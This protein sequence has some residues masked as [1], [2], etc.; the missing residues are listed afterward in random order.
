MLRE[1]SGLTVPVTTSFEAVATDVAAAR[2][3]CSGCSTVRRLT[4]TSGTTLT[5]GRLGGGIC[6]LATATRDAGQQQRKSESDADIQNFVLHNAKNP[7]KFPLDVPMPR[8]GGCALGIGR[9]ELFR[10]SP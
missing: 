10:T 4:S 2:A 1:M 3:N 7:D 5:G 8:T 6:L 9:I